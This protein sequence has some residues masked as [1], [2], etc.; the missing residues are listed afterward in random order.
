MLHDSGM[1]EIQYDSGTAAVLY[2]SPVPGVQMVGKGAKNMA[3]AR[4]TASEKKKKNAGKMDG[5]R[6]APRFLTRFSQFAPFSTI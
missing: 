2:D 4:R 6:G 3:T 5:Q 1:A